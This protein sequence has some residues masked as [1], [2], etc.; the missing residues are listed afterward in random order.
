MVALYGRTG[1]MQRM[2]TMQLLRL[3]AILG[4][5]ATHSPA[6][7]HIA[8][9]SEEGA[10]SA[11]YRVRFA[12]VHVAPKHTCTCKCCSLHCSRVQPGAAGCVGAS[13]AG[14]RVFHVRLKG[15]S[16]VPRT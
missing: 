12:T 7:A 9:C 4:D 15:N 13:R 1:V 2:V 3:G 8:H 10:V 5:G 6:P 16:P 11:Q 14:E